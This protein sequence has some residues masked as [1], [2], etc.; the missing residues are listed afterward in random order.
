MVQCQLRLE[1]CQEPSSD[2]ENCWTTRTR[3]LRCPVSSC[4]RCIFCVRY[5]STRLSPRNL[6]ADQLCRA[7]TKEE[8]LGSGVTVASLFFKNVFG[9]TAQRALSV[10]VALRWVTWSVHDSC[11]PEPFFSV[12]SGIF[13]LFSLSKCWLMCYSPDRLFNSVRFPRIYNSISSLMNN[14]PRMS[15]RL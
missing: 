6:P 3:N 12:H 13:I 8:I 10:F 1:Q 15:S 2:A 9:R 11:L 14:K 7:A 4:E 5:Y